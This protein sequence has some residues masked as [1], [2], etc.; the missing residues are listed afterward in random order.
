LY[1]LETQGKSMIDKS[2]YMDKPIFISKFTEVGITPE[3]LTTA[4]ASAQRLC[5]EAKLLNPGALA[6][7]NHTDYQHLLIELARETTT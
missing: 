4:A 2:D 1:L 3:S 6:A 5:L 7:C